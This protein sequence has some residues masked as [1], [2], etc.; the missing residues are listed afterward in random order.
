MTLQQAAFVHGFRGLAPKIYGLRPDSL[1]E[2][3][4]LDA[5]NKGESKRIE[6]GLQGITESDI[7]PITLLTVDQ[8]NQLDSIWR[9]MK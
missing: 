1:N 9:E 5:F 7:D 2:S 6:L 4:Y 3:Q 8:Q